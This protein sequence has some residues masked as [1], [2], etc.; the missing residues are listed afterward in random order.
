MKNPRLK[1]CKSAKENYI[2]KI[3]KT[4]N[5]RKDY[6]IEYM[7]NNT[8]D[9]ICDEKLIE[10]YIVKF[11]DYQL[12]IID[13]EEDFIIVSAPFDIV[14]NNST[15]ILN[16]KNDILSKNHTKLKVEFG[17]NV[18]S[19]IEFINNDESDIITDQ[20]V[21]SK[22]IKIKNSNSILLKKEK[23]NFKECT[24]DIDVKCVSIIDEEAN[25]LFD[26]IISK[27]ETKD[28][29]ILYQDTKYHK[30]TYYYHCIGTNGTNVSEISDTK[31]VEISEP[32]GEIKTV[33]EYSNDYNNIKNATWI[34][35]D[36]YYNPL[37]EIII[38]KNKDAIAIDVVENINTHEVQ[39]DDRLLSTDAIRTL[40]IPNIWHKDKRY[41]MQREKKIYRVKN[42]SIFDTDIR[43]EYSDIIKSEDKIEVLID[44][45]IILKKNVTGIDENEAAKPLALND[46]SATT[47]KIYIR[48]GGI[49]YKD[50]LANDCEVNNSN[51]SNTVSIV[52]LD[53]RFPLFSIKDNCIYSNKYNYTIYLFDEIGNISEPISVVL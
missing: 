45:M 20:D 8:P 10:G 6:S 7:M 28:S 44:K 3:F 33:L 26:P 48:Q 46:I 17:N 52:T 9:L 50:Y 22:L 49:Y 41:I 42:V 23:F 43:S 34:E 2:Y 51:A 12:P 24:I 31:A 36:K 16:F 30:N 35:V 15:F 53:S 37:R 38:P 13:N 19:T 29:I 21:I 11:E 14:K 1:F 40:K 5:T 32:I 39:V 25:G 47:L 27:I 4:K 18:I